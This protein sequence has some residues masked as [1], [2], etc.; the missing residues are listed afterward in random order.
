MVRSFEWN[1]ERIKLDFM[2]MLGVVVKDLEG[3]WFLSA[4]FGEF[5]RV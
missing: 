3:G 4:V 1:Y 2:E 5:Y